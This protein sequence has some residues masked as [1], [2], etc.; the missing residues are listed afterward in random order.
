LKKLHVIGLHFLFALLKTIFIFRELLGL[1]N[2]K[3][4]T[5]TER[6]ILTFIA[7]IYEDCPNQGINPPSVPPTQ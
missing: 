7:K 3:H 6:N 2:T 1:A 5:R 4:F